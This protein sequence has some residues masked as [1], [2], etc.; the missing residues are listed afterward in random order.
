MIEARSVV[1]SLLSVVG[2]CW[3]SSTSARVQRSSLL[4]TWNSIINPFYKRIPLLEPP[5]ML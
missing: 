5:L 3:S 1:D 2:Q 4:V